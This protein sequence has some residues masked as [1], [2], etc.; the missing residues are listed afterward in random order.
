MSANL[1]NASMQQIL[2]LSNFNLV[3]VCMVHGPKFGRHFCDVPQ[4]RAL[5]VWKMGL[6]SL[7]VRKKSRES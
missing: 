6:M 7:Y 2:Q 5:A 4:W 3:D 1:E